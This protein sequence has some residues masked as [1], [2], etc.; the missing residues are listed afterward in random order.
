MGKQ[1]APR[2]AEMTL[3][4]DDDLFTLG[5]PFN[6]VSAGTFSLEKVVHSEQLNEDWGR[7]E[8]Y[9][10]VSIEGL[11]NKFKSNTVTGYF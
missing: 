2:F 6:E 8:I 10:L 1:S 3:F 4:F 9:A 7:D 5:G 11:N